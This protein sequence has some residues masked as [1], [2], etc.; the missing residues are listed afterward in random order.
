MS[1]TRIA[2]NDTE[3]FYVEEALG[4]KIRKLLPSTDDEE[5]PEE[6]TEEQAKE[7]GD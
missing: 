2:I 7:E 1:E 4:K 6:T 3:V 5:K